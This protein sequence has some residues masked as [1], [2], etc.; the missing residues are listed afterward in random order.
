MVVDDHE[1]LGGHVSLRIEYL[2]RIYLSGYIP[3]LPV[4][5]QVA[6]FMTKILA[7]TF[8]RWRS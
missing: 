3:N 5:G 6:N 8:P 4:S 7:R 1:I 2:D